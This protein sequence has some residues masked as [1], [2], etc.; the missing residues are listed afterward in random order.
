M[1]AGLH[2]IGKMTA[3]DKKDLRSVVEYYENT[4]LDFQPGEKERYSPVAAFD[5]LAR[6]IEL[7]SDMK[8]AEFAEKN[9]FVPMELRDTTFTPTGEQWDRVTDMHNFKD[10][11]AINSHMQRGFIFADFP[12]SY[13][14]GGAGCV[15]TVNDYSKF[16]E[17][18]LNGG[19]SGGKRIISEEMIRLMQI[20][21]PPV[22]ANSRWENWGLGVRVNENGFYKEIP[23]GAYGWSGAYGTHFWV[24]PSNKITAVYMK[25]SLYDGG[26]GAVTA[27]HFEDD[28]NSALK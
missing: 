26:S 15:S 2:Y 20:P 18:L 1:D 10:G 13:T 9:I 21:R 12:A 3:D 27:R 5:V 23:N 8:F 4:P 22:D 24:D 7:T 19:V 11:R 14:C 17:M 16:A 6:L 25:N 28:V